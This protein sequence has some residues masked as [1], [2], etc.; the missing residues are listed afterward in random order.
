MNVLWAGLYLVGALSV[1]GLLV[2]AVGGWFFLAEW[3]RESWRIDE[4]QRE[5]E[6]GLRR[7]RGRNRFPPKDWTARWP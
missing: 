1:L 2:A 7:R 4:A 5:V 6:E 3:R